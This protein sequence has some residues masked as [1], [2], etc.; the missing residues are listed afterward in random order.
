MEQQEFDDLIARL[1][2]AA[3]QSKES[4][5]EKNAV[6]PVVVAIIGEKGHGKQTALEAMEATM[7]AR[8][9]EV[10][11]PDAQATGFPASCTVA[12][13]DFGDK[14][15]RFVLCPDSFEEQPHTIA[16]LSQ[17]DIC[18]AVVD[19]TC[20]ITDYLDDLLSTA[21]TVEC[22]RMVF[23]VSKC[24][25]VE[26]DASLDALEAALL[27]TTEVHMLEKPIIV[28]GCALGVLEDF[29]KLEAMANGPA[30]EAFAKE[31]AEEETSVT[32]LVESVNYAA[33]AIASGK[34]VEA[35]NSLK[36]K[37][38]EMLEGSEEGQ[39]AAA[40]LNQLLGSLD[41]LNPANNK[42]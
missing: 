30:K 12:D 6:E 23:Y 7:A 42:Q 16:T 15:F 33:F 2:T 27:K 37:V 14:Q 8:E 9:V 26:D 5:E 41:I 3:A 24:D 20:G 22:N 28:M 1:D 39:E 34:A 18:I 40:A 35:T 21:H 32:G 29:Q 4:A 13:A 36:E 10:S 17:S 31:L 11:H 19:A 38:S 25:L